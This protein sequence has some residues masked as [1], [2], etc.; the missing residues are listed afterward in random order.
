MSLRLA[1]EQLAVGRNLVASEQVVDLERAQIADAH[2]ARRD[3]LDRRQHLQLDGVDRQLLQH[4]TA[5]TAALFGKR[6]QDLAH[7]VPLDQRSEPVGVVDLEAGDILA[8]ERRLG[9]DECDRLAVV[10]AAQGGKQLHAELSGAEDD[11]G[12]A[13]GVGGEL[14]KADADALQEHRGDDPARCDEKRSQHAVGN[15]DRARDAQLPGHE[16]EQRPDQHRKPDA[17]DDPGMAAIA[18]IA[19]HELVET[20]QRKRRDRDQRRAQKQQRRRQIARHIEGRVAQRDR[21]PQR[22]A[23]QKEVP[24]DQ[25]AALI[26]AGQLKQPGLPARPQRMERRN[27]GHLPPCALPR[28]SKAA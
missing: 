22:H 12:L 10:G 13:L 4:A 26:E 7:I 5:L 14:G 21:Q 16:Y 15:H 2:A 28:Q 1:G 11:D 20:G 23:E 8:P 24:A 17:A 25:D 19:R 18:E 9:V 3:V 27:H 6:D